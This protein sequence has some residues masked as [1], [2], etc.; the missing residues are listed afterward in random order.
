[1]TLKYFFTPKDLI[2]KGTMSW[3]M[4]GK[5]HIMILLCMAIFLYFMCKIYKSYNEEKRDKFIKF[6]AYLIVIQEIIKDIVFYFMG[7]LNYEHLPFHLCGV[8]IFITLYYA[9]KRTYL[10]KQMLYALVLPGALSALIFPD[11]TN[12]PLIHVSPFNS[13]TIHLWLTVIPIVSIYTGELLPDYKSLPKCFLFL[14][15]IG[16]PDYFLNNMWGTNFLFVSTPS[17]GSPLMFVADIFG[18]KFYILG[19]CVLL[20]IVWNLMYLPFTYIKRK[21]NSHANA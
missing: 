12:F 9:V 8:S 18:E 13:F 21:Q 1:M 7:T 16:I 17:E 3:E 15:C 11:W 4:Y 14:V 10:S 6:F 20:F 2:P 5:E 19:M